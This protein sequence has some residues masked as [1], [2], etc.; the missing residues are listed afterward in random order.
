MAQM[1]RVLNSDA[2]RSLMCFA[3]NGIFTFVKQWSCMHERFHPDA[4]DNNKQTEF[5]NSDKHSEIKMYTVQETLLRW[6][7]R[8]REAFYDN[9]HLGR[10]KQ[11]Y[12]SDSCADGNPF[13]NCKDFSDDQWE[14]RR[15]LLLPNGGYEIL[16]CN[17]EDVQCTQT[18]ARHHLCKQ[19]LIPL[20]HHCT[21]AAWT[22]KYNYRIPM[23]R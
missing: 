3:C 17:P 20:C 6:L 2:I 8:N 23:V 16:L 15:Q 9:F 22:A 11:R 21:E 14:W 18:H 12:A 13:R 7:D 1:G 4:D 5:A 19:C 10:F